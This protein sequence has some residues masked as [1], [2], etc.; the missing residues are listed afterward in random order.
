MAL[1]Q[2]LE[3]ITPGCA[4]REDPGVMAELTFMSMCWTRG[5]DGWGGL[6]CNAFIG[7]RQIMAVV[8]SWVGY[9]YTR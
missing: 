2:M 3:G 4:R 8:G 9:K 7:L 1:H 6:L 5:M